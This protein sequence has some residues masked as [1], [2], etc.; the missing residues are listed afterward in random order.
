MQPTRLVCP[1]HC[2]LP[3]QNVAFIGAAIGCA[4]HAVHAG[5]SLWGRREADEPFVI[6]HMGPLPPCYTTAA[7][8]Q[9]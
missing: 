5:P 3:F 7:R 8:S 6:L 4:S 2:L 9:E 1:H